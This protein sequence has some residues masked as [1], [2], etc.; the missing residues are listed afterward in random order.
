MS[1]PIIPL[2]DPG[3][4]P[5]RRF[6]WVDEI[7]GDVLTV[8]EELRFI[9]RAPDDGVISN[10]WPGKTGITDPIIDIRNPLAAIYKKIPAGQQIFQKSGDSWIIWENGES[11]LNLLDAQVEAFPLPNQDYKGILYRRVLKYG[12]SLPEPED[13]IGEAIYK[14][15]QDQSLTIQKFDEDF[16]EG[17]GGDLLVLLNQFV[18]LM[19]ANVGDSIVY[20]WYSDTQIKVL[21][22]GQCRS[23]DGQKTYKIAEDMIVEV[24][25]DPNSETYIHTPDSLLEVWIYTGSSGMEINAMYPPVY[26]GSSAYGAQLREFL[27]L[28]SNGDLLPFSAPLLAHVPPGFGCDYY[29]SIAPL[30]W[31]HLDG[32][33]LN[34]EFFPQLASM[35]SGDLIAVS[36]VSGYFWQSSTPHGIEDEAFVIWS[37]EEGGTPAYDPNEIYVLRRAS[38]GEPPV[39]SET[40]FFMQYGGLPATPA[41]G[42][43]GNQFVREYGV[44]LTSVANKIIKLG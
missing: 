37:C 28:D 10:P 30:G 26:L 32:S 16:D 7:D 4:A 23:A 36:Y 44:F 43:S 9:G 34:G 24:G 2:Y 42:W 3:P 14:A 8:I 31:H 5:A 1:D 6:T 12:S 22:G 17:A 18:D 25:W 39:E 27:L 29:G 21:A 41:E 20:E 38:E 15:I 40:K 19:G 11:P 33:Q 35:L 13:I